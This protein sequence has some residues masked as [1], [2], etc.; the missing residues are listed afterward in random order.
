MRGRAAPPPPRIYRVPPGAVNKR[1]MSSR[2]YSDYRH[3][4]TA[5]FAALIFLFN[6]VQFFFKAEGQN[7]YRNYN[8]NEGDELIEHSSR[9]CCR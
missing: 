7:P 9:K 8:A 5:V 1:Q 3:V 4:Q 6:P 2:G